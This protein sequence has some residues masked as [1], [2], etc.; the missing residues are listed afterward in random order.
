M[1]SKIGALLLSLAIAFGLWFY[2]ITVVSPESE[3]T[4][5]E[6]PIVMNGENILNDRGLMILSGKNQ[7]VDLKLEGY[8]TDLA[9]LNKANI[10]LLTDLSQITTAGEHK[11]SY[12]ISYSI[13]QSG[14]LTVLEQT[15]KLITVVVAEQTKKEIPV[16]VVYTGAVPEDYIAHKQSV[17]LDHTTVT[18]SGPKD[19]VDKIAKAKV[20]VDLTDKTSTISG[21]YGFTLCDSWGVPATDLSNVTTN[22]HEV[23][24]TLRIQ[25]TK[26]IPLVLHVIYGGGV[27]ESTSRIEMDMDAV[28]VAGSEVA[29]DRLT[30]IVLGTV[31]LSNMLESTTLTYPIILPEDVTNVTNV[32]EVNVSV[33]F[34]DLEIR[35]YK[36]NNLVAK[37]LPSGLEAMW[38]TTSVTVRLRGETE[39]LK[40]LTAQDISVVVDLSD[41]EIGAQIYA[42]VIQ[43]NTDAVVGSIGNYEVYVSV[44]MRTP[45]TPGVYG[46]EG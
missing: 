18:I 31:D 37:N 7:T 41:A 22:L 40:N 3:D 15:P 13:A 46:T 8:R 14:P 43:V 33:S 44:Q 32:S 21:A 16:E 5:H 26:L 12:D 36:V 19:V 34:P 10:I 4:F 29:L 9:S 42:A 38:L 2:V 30:E 25:K 20:S 23:R 28:Q 35:E 11:L 24:V 1:K 39:V 17:L 27:T 45:L 6:I